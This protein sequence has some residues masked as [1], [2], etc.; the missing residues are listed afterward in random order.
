MEYRISE[1]YGRAKET[2]AHTQA[3]WEKEIRRARKETFKTQSINVK[4][5]EELKTVRAA[6][7]TLEDS[8][9]RE[10]ERSR[11]REQEAFEARY[12]I[13]GVQEQLEAA[14]ARIKLVEQERDAFKTAA[15]NEGVARVAAEGRI[16]LPLQDPTDE[17]ASPPKK[18]RPAGGSPPPPA[19]LSY[20]QGQKKRK[21]GSRQQPRFSLSSVEIESEL[22]TEMELEQLTNQVLWERQRA[23]RADEMIEFL[24]AE[25]EMKICPCGRSRPR[26][27]PRASPRLARESLSASARTVE[28]EG[29]PAPGTPATPPLL[30]HSVERSDIPT[31]DGTSRQQR[32]RHSEEDME[33]EQQREEQ[34]QEEETVMRDT[35]P[36]P[37]Q[38]QQQQQQQ[39]ADLHREIDADLAVPK[40]RK[41]S[42]RST[43]FYPK[44]GIFRT[45]SE[46]EAQAL[47]AQKE[48][49]VVAQVEEEEQEKDE[50][51]EEQQQQQLAGEEEQ[52]ELEELGR[53]RGYARTPSVE[54]PSFALPRNLSQRTSLMSLLNAPHNADDDFSTPKVPMSSTLYTTVTTTVPVQDEKPMFSS[55]SSL[56][57]DK[58]RTPSSGAKV[59]F[60]ANNPALTPT[61]TREQALAK[62]RERRGRARS[63]ENAKA[64]PANKKM[65]VKGRRDISAPTRKF[66]SNKS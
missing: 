58:L 66:G 6:V 8:V 45:V 62:I 22:A 20:S 56:L 43:L 15:K 2:H 38:Q 59:S 9:E 52:T 19:A 39:E 10:R 11:V 51:E 53:G 41:S 1:S 14:L 60:D 17:F 18:T 65:D 27:S 28:A 61:M 37:V 47:K 33:P 50:E 24:Q 29:T 25:C 31:E 35:L 3:L 40:A 16:P 55:T 4:L 30:R 23:D 42:R 26:P 32:H 64:T 34:V 7:K 5:Q 21:T 48:V 46:Q 57:A 36:T 54:P 44:E 63:A 49:E 13:V 12:Q